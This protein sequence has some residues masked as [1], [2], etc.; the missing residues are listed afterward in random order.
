[1]VL[2]L[3]RGNWLLWTVALILGLGLLTWEVGRSPQEEATV[4]ESQPKARHFDFTADLVQSVT[5]TRSGPPPASV[6]LYR[7]AK[8]SNGESVWLMDNPQPVAVSGPAVDFLL[9]VILGSQNDRNFEVPTAEL[10]DYGLNPAG[11]ELTIQLV[12]GKTHRLQLGNPD[13]A[14]NSL[15]ALVNPVE[16]TDIPVESQQVSLVPRSLEELTRRSPADWQQ[17]DLESD[18]ENLDGSSPDGR[19]SSESPA[20]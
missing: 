7:Q 19:I 18:G 1:M 17:A 6:K 8:A 12:N 15:Y 9:S 5:I 20:R 2:K 3:K 13:F 14:G 4:A 10:T 16:N 11:T